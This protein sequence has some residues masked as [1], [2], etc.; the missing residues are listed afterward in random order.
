MLT[1][2]LDSVH[3]IDSSTNQTAL[4][5]AA[6]KESSRTAQLLIR[7]LARKGAKLPPATGKADWLADVQA[8]AIELVDAPIQP[9]SEEGE[10]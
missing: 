7:I 1:I 5:A 9:E 3:R 2:L 4:M 8:W 10:H 6:V